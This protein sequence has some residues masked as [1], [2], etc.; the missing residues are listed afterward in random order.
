MQVVILAGSNLGN[1]QQ[2]LQQ[3]LNAM[4]DVVGRI[5]KISSI[6]ET[7]PWGVRSQPWYLN[8]G[9]LL[10]TSLSPQMLL[11]VLKRLEQAAGRSPDTNGAPRALDLDILLYDQ[12]VLSSPE[13]SL[14][15]PRLH[16]RRFAL[17]PLVELLPH[18]VHPLLK[19]TAIALLHQCKDTSQVRRLERTLY[20]IQPLHARPI[21]GLESTPKL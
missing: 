10:E 13:L 11:A 5:I 21:T 14:P 17:T 16:R 4:H 20:I 12:L 15:H 7:E 3:A 2:Q 9:V 8:V 18:W 6:Y 19:K 1:R